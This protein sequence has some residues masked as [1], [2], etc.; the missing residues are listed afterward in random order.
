MTLEMRTAHEHKIINDFCQFQREMLVS[1]EGIPVTR[2]G[3]MGGTAD[4]KRTVQDRN[5]YLGFL[6]VKINQLYA[7][8]NKIKQ[9]IDKEMREQAVY[10]VY[11]KR[12]KT[13]VLDLTGE[14]CCILFSVT[15]LRE[16][17]RRLE[18]IY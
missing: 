11:D 18:L 1:E 4:P 12:V 5:Y 16:R 2:G 17:E 8:I 3:T 7:E 6:T 14:T 10:H 13:L 15:Y 9:N